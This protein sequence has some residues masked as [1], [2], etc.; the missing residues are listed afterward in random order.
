MA[1]TVPLE[2]DPAVPVGRDLA[3]RVESEAIAP[4]VMHGG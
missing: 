4:V 3:L 2:S 1:E